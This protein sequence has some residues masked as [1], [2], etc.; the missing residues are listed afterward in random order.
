MSK[1]I[2]FL[3]KFL[4]V[5]EA[6]EKLVTSIVIVSLV[7][8][9]GFIIKGF[10][11]SQVKSQQEIARLNEAEKAR[12]E[13][14]ARLREKV[15]NLESSQQS[16]RSNIE[17][18]ESKEKQLLAQIDE[19]KSQIETL[20]SKNKKGRLSVRE[21]NTD[22][23]IV[24]EFKNTF[25]EITSTADFGT[26]DIVDSYGFVDTYVALPVTHL[27]LF[28][29]EHNELEARDKQIDEYIQIEN[30]YGKA[31]DLNRRIIESE[32]KIFD[33]ERQ[34]SKAY[35][36]GMESRDKDLALE[37]ERYATCLKKPRIDLGSKWS[38]LAG[39][40]V[41]VLGCSALD[42]KINW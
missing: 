17:K 31:I 15:T 10:I 18:L 23:A 25:P 4:D 42:I 32:R 2:E 27:K 14:N 20:E 28:I 11:N 12:I 21:L 7:I 38:F 24:Q 1:V 13:E 33:L 30:K 34:V 29:L 3:K 22:N 6:K 8:T 37:R 16:L 39:A 41:G 5:L 40:G 26:T 19:H 36:E 9:F 35:Q